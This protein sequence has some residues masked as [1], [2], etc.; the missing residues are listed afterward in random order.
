MVL[1]QADQEDTP[2]STYQATFDTSPEGD[3][4]TVRLPWHNFVPVKRAQSDPKGAPLDPSQISKLGLVLSRYD[5]LLYDCPSWPGCQNMCATEQRSRL[6]AI[7]PD[8]CCAPASQRCDP[9]GAPLEPSHGSAS[10]AWC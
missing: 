10:W 2:E 8:C 1:L 3:W 4:T 7:W 6:V 5:L 9:K